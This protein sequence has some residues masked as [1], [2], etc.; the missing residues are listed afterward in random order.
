MGSYAFAPEGTRII[1][2]TWT[3]TRELLIAITCSMCGKQVTINLGHVHEGLGT[4]F[5]GLD[6]LG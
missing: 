6:A 4:T 3:Q 5:P 1:R 2:M